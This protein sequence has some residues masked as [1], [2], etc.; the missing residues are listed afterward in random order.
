MSNCHGIDDD[1]NDGE[2]GGGGRAADAM[3]RS[4]RRG[5]AFSACGGR[6]GRRDDDGDAGARQG[7]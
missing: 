3:P 6:G 4:D 5:E 1:R 7:Q 2:G